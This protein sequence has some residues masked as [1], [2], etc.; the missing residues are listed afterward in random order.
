MNKMKT[1]TKY[2]NT[3]GTMRKQEAHH[4]KQQRKKNLISMTLFPR[5][6]REIGSRDQS[7]ESLTGFRVEH[8]NLLK[9]H[10]QAWKLLTKHKAL[11]TCK[12][13]EGFLF[14]KADHGEHLGSTV[15]FGHMKPYQKDR[16][17]ILVFSSPQ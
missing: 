17:F 9:I 14:L 4:Q 13:R 10:I 8:G 3:S 15:S 12:Q 7:Y 11:V 1:E 5:L 2:T 16:G 6:L